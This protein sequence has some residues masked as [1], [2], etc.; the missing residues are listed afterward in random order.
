MVDPINTSASLYKP[1]VD[2]GNNNSPSKNY[3]SA[4]SNSTTKIDTENDK[5]NKT[6]NKGDI[7]KVADQ[8]NS[9]IESTNK[10]LKFFVHEATG[11]IAVKVINKDT[12]EVIKEIPAKELLDLQA[13]IE[14]MVGMLIDKEI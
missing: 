12:N 5:E 1:I 13:K 11:Q 2:T 4:L 10:S 9:K 3:E 14:D 6:L 7:E 8:I